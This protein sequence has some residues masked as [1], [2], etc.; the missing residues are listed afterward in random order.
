MTDSNR[1]K[2]AV[3]GSTGEVGGRVAAGLAERGI[4]QRL[5]VRDTDRAPKLPGAEIFQ[6]SSF[7]D[8]VA[9]GKALTGMEK[10][11]LVSA[12]DKFG[13]ARR[14]ATGVYGEYDRVRQQTTIVDVAAAVGVKHIIYLSFLNASPDSTF[15]LARDHFHTESHIQNLGI[16]YTFLR[17]GL[18]MD[19]LPEEQTSPDGVIRAPAGWGRAAWVA[20]DDL[21]DVAISVLT[22]DGHEGCT[23]N[24]TG[25]EAL[26]L[27]E[28]ADRLSIAAGRKIIYQRQ[29]PTEARATRSTTGLAEYE[30]ERFARTG[31]G[32]DDYEV[33]VWVTHWLQ[34]ATGEISTVSD[35]VPLLT[36]HDACSLSQYLKN[37]PESCRRLQ[38]K[39]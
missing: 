21:A 16:S 2:I 15:I 22:G 3:T 36:G 27:D 30:A 12:H 6:A 18:Y 9:V 17:M 1:T 28:T 8:A 19:L 33:E 23:Y 39:Q 14:S 25:P 34:I 10:L 4:S 38:K 7:G 20:R 26:S 11:F 31:K 37:Y 32:L 29:T 35:A 24:V 13:F 5:I